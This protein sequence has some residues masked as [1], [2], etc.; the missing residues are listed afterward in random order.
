MRRF[1]I[2]SPR[3]KHRPS[4]R[5]TPCTVFHGTLTC[6]AS[7]SRNYRLYGQMLASVMVKRHCQDHPKS[8]SCLL[9]TQGAW[10]SQPARCKSCTHAKKSARR[11]PIASRT[12]HPVRHNNKH[13]HLLPTPQRLGVPRSLRLEATEVVIRGGRPGKDA[14]MVLVI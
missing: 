14:S 5:P 11:L 13:K 2:S 8:T 6:S 10:Y 3:K 4:P 1:P 12:L 9:W 7:S